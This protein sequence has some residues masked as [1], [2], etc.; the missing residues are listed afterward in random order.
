MSG[1]SL[2]TTPTS[3]SSSATRRQRHRTGLWT[4]VRAEFLSLET[5]NLMILP[6]ISSYSRLSLQRSPSNQP[7]RIKIRTLR[8]SL[9][10]QKLRNRRPKLG[11]SPRKPRYSLRMQLH[12]LVRSIQLTTRM[13]ISHRLQ[14]HHP[15][16]YRLQSLEGAE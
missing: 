5:S 1:R 4:S 7:K 8:T 14:R 10:S 2:T 11:Y 12:C 6:C 9:P 13:K 15:Q 3:V 16:R